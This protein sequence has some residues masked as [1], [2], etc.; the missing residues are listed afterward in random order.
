ML[1][2]DDTLLKPNLLVDNILR[3]ESDSE[4]CVCARAFV[5]W[6]WEGPLGLGGMGGGGSSTLGE[7]MRGIDYSKKD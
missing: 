5:M 4:K 6:W 1:E 7:I 3:L 2:S